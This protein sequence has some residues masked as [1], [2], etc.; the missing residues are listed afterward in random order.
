MSDFKFGKDIRLFDACRLFLFKHK[1]YI[2]ENRLAF[3][4]YE[5]RCTKYALIR[6]L[7]TAAQQVAVFGYVGLKTLAGAVTL[8]GFSVYISSSFV[9]TSS[10][11]DAFNQLFILLKNTDFL[12]EYLQF[13]RLPPVKEQRRG[14]VPDLREHVFEF[15][16]VS[17]RYPGSETMIL[18][19]VSIRIPSGQRLSIVGMNGAGKTTF[20]KLLTRLYDPTEGEILLDGMDIRKIDLEEYYR[21]FSVVFQDFRLFAFSMKENIVLDTEATAEKL[22][23]IVEMAGLADKVDALENGLETSVYK[24]FDKN[25]VELSGGES[26]KLSIARALY[27]DRPVVV[28]DEPTASLDPVAEY[29]IYRRFDRLVNGKTAIYISHRLSSCRF[30]DAIAV[31]HEGSIIQY[32]HHDVL[33]RETGKKYLEMFHAQ[34][35]YYV[36]EEAPPKA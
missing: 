11:S 3:L 2:E 23:S 18:K 31:F 8:G 10:A 15:R 24:T 33:I 6:A 29:E 25:G 14:K 35:Q 20:I 16:N 12:C 22:R 26:Q 30:C 19:N 27:M 34:A 7:V 28:L 17:F 5:K 36:D 32:G 9:F 4:A 13:M 1:E 21:L